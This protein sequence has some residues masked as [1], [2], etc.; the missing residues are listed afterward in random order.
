MNTISVISLVQPF[1]SLV[2]MGVKK[3][4]TRSWDTK[5]RGELYIHASLGKSYGKISCRELCYTEPF[6]QFINGGL[7]YDKLP[8]GAIIG[9]V[10]LVATSILCPPYKDNV[11]PFG[12]YYNNHGAAF[13]EQELAFGDFEPGR[14]GWLLSNPVLLD[15]PIPAK[16][17]QGF[18]NYDLNT[19]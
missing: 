3:I 16:G 1:A 15:A 19:E 13:T 9:K 18:W 5:F 2:V 12:I 7:A 14:Y 11:S 10:D 6:K 4:E 8:F 17:K